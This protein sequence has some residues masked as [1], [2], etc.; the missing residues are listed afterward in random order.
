MKIFL[1]KLKTLQEIA[2]FLDTP[3]YV[4]NE[5]K[6]A[7]SEWVDAKAPVVF[8]F[9]K[10]DQ[11][12]RNK[13]GKK[14][15]EKMI[16]ALA[17][18]QTKSPKITEIPITLIEIQNKI[19]IEWDFERL[20]VEKIIIFGKEVANH[21]GIHYPLYE[22]FSIGQVACLISD[23]LRE[24]EAEQSRKMLLWNNLLKMFVV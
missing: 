21:I 3:I 7:L 13:Q 17:V 18:R 23:T 2:L 16:A 4:I 8:F 14:V 22:I 10:S 9:E 11:D 1:G 15:L 6:K 19:R 20:S 5:N 12:T 24:I